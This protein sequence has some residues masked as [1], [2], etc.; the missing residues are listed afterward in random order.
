MFR[1]CLLVG[2]SY[3]YKCFFT[4]VLPFLSGRYATMYFDLVVEPTT[5]ANRL[6]KYF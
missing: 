2:R 5:F 3:I 4:M 6:Q 1:D